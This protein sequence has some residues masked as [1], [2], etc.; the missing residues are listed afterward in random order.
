MAEY[1]GPLE[2]K[3]GPERIG[4]LEDVQKKY[5]NG[6][7]KPEQVAA[8]DELKRRGKWEWPQRRPR[9][10]RREEDIRAEIEE[11]GPLMSFITGI[12][13]GVQDIAR[14]AGIAP[15]PTEREAMTRG[16]LKEERPISTGAGEITGQAAPFLIPGTQVA[17]IP[18][19]AV[20][21]V[22]T[23]AL[24]ATEAG[25][26]AE[27]TGGE[28]IPAAGIGAGIGV[29]AEILFPI[30]G[31]L[32]RRVYQR[33]FNKAPKGALL[34]PSGQPTKE[35]QEALDAEG[36]SFNE[37][38]EDAQEVINQQVPGASPGQVA[39]KARFEEAGIPPTRGEITQGFKQ[40]ALEQRLLESGEDVAAEPFRQFKLKQS[41]A[42]KDNLRKNFDF[43]IEEEET[44]QLIKDALTGRR[45]L[46]RSEKNELYSK[47]MEASKDVA[48]I[49]VFTDTI[50]EAI[51]DKM[52]MERLEILDSTGS[53]SLNDWLVRFGIKEPSQEMIDKGFIPE[54][55]NLENFELFRQGLNQISKSSDAIKNAT[56]PLTRALDIEGDEL[57]GSVD[58]SKLAGEVLDS[59]KQAR[60]TVRQLKTEF[61]PQ[62]VIGKVTDVKRDGVTP[63]IEAS[64][65]YSNL[66]GRS[67]PVENTRKLI[68]SL[69]KSGDK[70][71]EALAALQTSTI[72]DLIS[73]GFGTESRKIS[74]IKVFNPIAFKNRIKN[75]GHDK[76]NAIFSNNK[77]V[78]N[79][80]KNV[81]KIATDLIPEA[82]AVPKGSASVI[83]DLVNR[84]GGYSIAGKV[85]GGPIL[86]ETLNKIVS[87]IKTGVDVKKALDAAP[88]VDELSY[89]FDSRFPGISSALGIAVSLEERENDE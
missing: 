81:E 62:S 45:K 31:R 18:S 37:L 3:K 19:M 34:D 26:I 84:L 36:M 87:P 2:E 86:M 63:V 7:L 14:G 52:T 20:R 77:S 82:G 25:L 43:T 39:R 35:L 88:E 67:N 27:G 58:E 15:E 50:T 71:K 76:I 11:V 74:G 5:D 40:R 42:I 16:M 51:P 53:K 12:G 80:L 17:K 66:V 64:K 23:G 46:L 70:G 32:G 55:I 38:V 24:G 41:E 85:P 73:A 30:I 59:L 13:Y 29:G 56:G 10:P 44:G 69:N 68:K 61:S 78:L 49:P 8:V 9:S 47:A 75:I 4:P 54:T 21:A 57:L 65:I 33:T 89:L 83:L 6:E 22:T 60:R 72:L 79:R 1:L 48:D 28:A